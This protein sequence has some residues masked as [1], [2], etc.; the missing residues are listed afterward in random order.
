VGLVVGQ[1]D[2]VA[3]VIPASFI[4]P[5][6]EAQRGSYRGLGW[7]AFVWQ[8][9]RNPA[10]HHFLKQ[11]GE[12]QG[13]VIIDAPALGG[14]AGVLQPRDV[15]LQVD[16]FDIDM[17]GDYIDPAYG[18]L[19]L[20]NLATRRHWA[21]DEIPLR[22]WREGAVKDVKYR[23]PKAAY[24][25]D[26]VPQEVFDRPPEY[27][28]VGG[29]LFQPL[30]EPYLRSWGPDWRRRVP[31]RLAY[32]EQQKPTAERPAIV[33]LSMVLP[34]P[35]NIGYQ[36][37]RFLAVHAINGR[38]VVTLRDAQQALEHPE[39]GFHVIDFDRGDSLQRIVLDADTAA[40][41]T[42]RVMERYGITQA[43]VLAKPAAP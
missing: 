31:F 33:I 23:L 43:S 17:E 16:G 37:Y 11:T 12:P 15:L 21:G 36:D 35:Y 34:D 1:R 4:R 24:T 26:L 41:A 20:E 9:G 3:A 8:R 39:K 27:L 6:L 30:T 19:L 22:I 13:V 25:D 10:L 29:L 2:N 14:N 18:K 42:R 40:A 7:F 28:V 32:Y 38:R 5:I